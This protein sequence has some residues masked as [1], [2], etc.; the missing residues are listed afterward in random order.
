M[1]TN[2]TKLANRVPTITEQNRKWWVVVAIGIAGILVSVDFNGLTVALPTI[3]RDLGISTTGLQWTINAYLL[4]FAAPMVAFGR[5][6]DI[7]G[8]RRV[9]L[10]GITIFIAASAFAG[11]SQ[12]ELWLVSARVV[13]GLGAAAFFAASLPIVSHAFPEK[14][15][16]KGIALWAAISGLGL[17]AGPLV[18]GVL[19]QMVSWRWFFFFNVPLA[20]V[21]VILTLAAVRESRD[22]TVGHHVDFA[23]LVTVTGGLVALVL[24]IQQGD[25]LGWGS[26]FVIGA[27][28]AAVLLLAAFFVIERRT[29][30]PLIEL[31]LF[32][33]RD[34]LGANAV[35]FVVNY[36]F[37]AL[38]FYMTLYLQNI[39]DY[40]PLRTGLVFLAF[41]VPLVVL[42][43][44]TNDVSTRL[45]VRNSMV[46]GMA[47]MAVAFVF[48]TRVTPTSGLVTV[49]VSLVL[50][51]T[52]IGVAYTLSNTVGMGALPDAKGGE[53]SGVLGMVRLLGAVFGVAVTGAL[54]KTLENE[55]LAELLV[56]AGA[57][58]DASDRQEIKGLLSGSD[59]AETTLKH[60][61]PE[62]ES[63]VERIVHVAFVSAFGR[64]M[65]LCMAV[66]ILGVIA[67]YFIIEAA[68]SE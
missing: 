4:A 23:G 27:L 55:K 7:F 51:G 63:Q 2:T 65:L 15:R 8:R 32:A 9:L 28:G 16:G 1:G 47:L 53:A 46:G 21:A 40:S 17:A 11:F 57:A 14:E 62:V 66:S 6:S 29:D 38:L 26:P 48:L 45:G 43:A 35:G 20:A 52:G 18:G 59:A 68:S 56:K 64:A 41:T 12:S 44:R 5:L 10:I 13:Q 50:A 22:E 58:L 54:F 33:N 30:D 39:L 36:G 34:F 24:A 31:D 19:T 67:A 37:G 42:E 49:L 25:T 3:G 61:A 60:L